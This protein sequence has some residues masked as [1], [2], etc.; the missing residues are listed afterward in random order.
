MS[1]ETS[2][3]NM[4]STVAQVIGNEPRPAVQGLGIDDVQGAGIAHRKLNGG[5]LA[6]KA[7]ELVDGSG[8]TFPVLQWDV[9]DALYI[10]YQTNHAI[11]L[12]QIVDDHLHF[13]TDIDS[14]GKRVKFEIDI[15]FGGMNQKNVTVAQI[16]TEH[17][18]GGD[19]SFGNFLMKL[20]EKDN[21]NPTVSTLIDIK[22]KRVTASQDDLNA[23]G[24]FYF[25][26][27]DMHMKF[28]Q[29]FGSR[30]GSAK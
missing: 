25:R 5:L 17:T 14:T 24:K 23:T 9:N 20:F 1:T 29:I 28:N 8:I 10:T 19:T 12:N 13:M 3:P 27:Q 30:T 4:E 16:V 18:F 7:V 2:Q 26:F 11:S 21:I 22:V 15:V 6:V